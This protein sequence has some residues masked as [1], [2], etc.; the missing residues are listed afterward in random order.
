MKTTAFLKIW[1]F[2]AAFVF[3]SFL[4]F[5]AIPQVQAAEIDPDGI[6][7][8]GKTI[9]DDLI[10]SGENVRIDGTVNGLLIAFGNTVRI[11]GI[12][13]GDLIAFARTIVVSK[14][15]VIEGN[16]FTGA[17][18][19][20][21]NG[22]V[23]G[24]LLA[25]G[26]TLDLGKTAV[27]NRNVYYGGYS[28]TQAT[29]SQ[30][31]RDLRAGLYQAQLNGEI[32]QDAVVY[33]EAIEVTGSIARNADFITGNPD[34]KFESPG[35]FMTNMGVTES[36][37]PGLRI[38]DEA[39]IGGKMVYTSKVE[40]KDSI[41]ASP[42][43]GIVYQTPVPTTN[44]EAESIPGTQTVQNFVLFE[45]LRKL[46]S[47][48][49][50]LLLV[51]TL[52]LWKVPGEL[53][54]NIDMVKAS[55]WKSLGMGFVTILIGYAAA[56]L[57]LFVIILV[58]VILGFISFGGLGSITIFT[59]LSLLTAIVALF[60]VAI[61][62]VSKIIVAYLAGQWIYAKLASSQTS[63]VWPLIIGLAIYAVLQ[64]IPFINILIT[65]TVTLLGVGA[66]YLVY[67]NRSTMQAVV[68]Q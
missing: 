67:R 25:G 23:T 44:K 21:V 9:N 29:G 12:V 14:D 56:F 32:G 11:N 64:T 16:I 38:S 15:A 62:L 65:L 30:I 27:I 28:F 47:T 60:G 4:L 53:E 22:K 57:A 61:S 46:A 6:V 36:L 43:E 58:G 5:A 63:K 2:F 33:G 24:S 35:P 8:F 40:Q 39:E 7:E 13:D 26:A 20:T 45:G 49:I 48:F 10:I 18:N 51:G 19:I 50:S 37:N 1:R 31:D 59:G 42:M 17:Q 54:K 52:I 3:L 55:P 68:N 66:M 41:K 34:E